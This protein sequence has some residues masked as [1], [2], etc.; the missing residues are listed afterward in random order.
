LGI[1]AR[2]VPLKGVVVALHAMRELLAKKYSVE[3]H[4][5][6]TGPLQ[7]KLTQDAAALGISSSVV[8]HGCVQDMAGFYAKI[9]LLIVPSVREPF[10]MVI[11]EAGA[12]G[13]P[14]VATKVDGIPEALAD[15]KTGLCVPADL[16][17]QPNGPFGANLADFPEV[18]YNPDRDRLEPPKFLDPKRLAESIASLLDNPAK[19]R[20]FSAAAIDHARKNFSA[21]AYSRLLRQ[22]FADA[23]AVAA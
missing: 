2:L 11:V 3:L 20:D 16:E 13:C 4:I 9:D 19:Y 6:G 18:V 1:A 17:L 5:A 12:H 7:S 8:F 15:G 21:E 23:M 10:G 22:A 14:A